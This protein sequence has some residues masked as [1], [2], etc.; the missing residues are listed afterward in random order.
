MRQAGCSFA[1]CAAAVNK[2]F[3]GNV[4]A[5]A[6]RSAYLRGAIRFSKDIPDPAPKIVEV[7]STP[8]ISSLDPVVQYEQRKAAS[9]ERSHVKQLIEQVRELR[10]RQEFLDAVNAP[11]TPHQIPR[12]ERQS[13]HREMT[14]AALASDWHVE[15]TVEAESVAGR[16]AYNLDVADLRI[17]KFFDAIIWNVQHNRASQQV[18]IRDLILWLG[19]DLITGYIHEELVETNALSPTETVRWLLPRLYEG[20]ER[21]LAELDLASIVVPCSY[22]NHGRTTL[23]SRVQSGYA[24][25]FEWLMYHSLADMFR[26]AGETRVVFEITASAH[27][28][29]QAYEFTLHFHHGDS[30]TYK[31]GV[32]GLAIPLLK[33]VPA[34]DSIRYAHY[35]HIGHFHQLSDFGRAVVNG[36]LIG[37]GPYSQSIR[38]SFEVPQQAFYLLDSKRGKCIVTPLWVN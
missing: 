18:L 32:G 21:L 22:G 34:W 19:G 35:H 33:A 6:A 13:G 2:R 10:A 3:G 27:Q 38:A 29:I 31:G 8:A 23:K 25:S 1:E 7:P 9:E 36:S 15:E 30:L 11:H 16:N 24:N 17:D 20:I 26:A 14:A 4:G 5:D 12:R 28:Y 37:Y